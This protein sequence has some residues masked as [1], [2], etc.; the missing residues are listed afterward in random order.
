MRESSKHE[1]M[2]SD[3]LSGVSGCLGC[4]CTRLRRIHRLRMPSGSVF[5]TIRGCDF[6]KFEARRTLQI[7][8]LS[9]S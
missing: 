3:Q 2:V 4:G 1:N 9:I 7:E 5:G 8:D 6:T